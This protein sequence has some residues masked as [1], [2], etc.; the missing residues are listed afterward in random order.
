MEVFRIK[1]LNESGVSTTVYTLNQMMA[2]GV[3]L[4]V[5]A[6]DFDLTIFWT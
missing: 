3:V 5:G 1:T 4:A 6:L 2:R